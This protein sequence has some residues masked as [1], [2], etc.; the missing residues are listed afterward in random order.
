MHYKNYLLLAGLVLPSFV[1][2]AVS[3]RKKSKKKE[4]VKVEVKARES[5][6]EAD[7]KKLFKDKKTVTT[8][9]MFTI[10][11]VDESKLYFELPIT[12]LEREM[13]L[14]STVSEISNNAHGVI[15]YKP[16]EPLHVKFRKIGRGVHLCSVANLYSASDKEEDAGIDEAVRK[17]TLPSIY[18]SYKIEAYTPDSS[19]MVIDVTDLFLEDNPHLTP[20]DQF[21]IFGRKPY[22]RTTKFEKTKSLLG[23][24]KAFED[25]L[26]IK[27]YLSYSVD[28]M[29]QSGNQRAS[30]E[31]KRAFTAY[32]TRTLML[33]PDT[34]MRPRIADPRMN[35]FYSGKAKFTH[36]M[37][38]GTLPTYYARHWRV[39]PADTN[40]YKKGELVEPKQP[41]VFYVDKNF[42]DM[43][44]PYI[45]AGIQEWN[46]AFEK[47]GFKNVVKSA[48]Y[49]E[50]D[51]SFDPDNLK[52]SCVRYAPVSIMNAMGPSWDDPRTGEIINASVMVYH[53]IMKLITNWR[54]L[55]TA[56]SDPNARTMNM[57]E[58]VM[59]DALRYVIAHEIGHCLGFM[60][61]MSA[62]AVIPTDSLRSP[63]FTQKYGTTMSIMDYA[64][65]N[66]VAQPGDFEKGVKVTPPDMGVYDYYA[67]KW[68]YTPLLA[69]KTA[70]EELPILNKWIQEK[71]NDPVYR[72]GK[73]Q[74]YNT[75]D[76]S[77]QAEDL[78]DDLIKGAEYGIKNLRY[79]LSN[80]NSWVDKDDQDLM[81]RESIYR[82]MLNQYMTFILHV[83]NVKGGVYMN[84][85]MAGDARPAHAFV[86]GEYQRR[87]QQFLIN[88]LNDLD[89]IDNND[90]MKELP[91]QGNISVKIQKTLL[92]LILADRGSL[93]ILTDPAKNA[94]SLEENQDSAFKGIFAKTIK[95]QTLSTRDMTNQIDYLDYL[96]ILNRLEKPQGSSNKMGIFSEAESFSIT[97]EIKSNEYMNATNLYAEGNIDWMKK[98]E[99]EEY[100]GFAW[101][102]SLSQSKTAI[103]HIYYG[104]LIELRNLLRRMKNT[105]SKA[106]RDHYEMMLHRLEGVLN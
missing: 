76:P 80:I 33:L 34:L 69:A 18:R 51:P 15:G 25:N 4:D 11:K 102:K 28:V 90:L 77:S 74:I 79:I 92:S 78:G 96:L 2:G 22:S 14:G 43:W 89:W 72:Y 71:S 83:Y 105:G 103:D 56:A 16:K 31:S 5:K 87:A 52:Y 21:S 40:K 100:M 50:N 20:F 98:I 38:R 53:D 57:S 81:F 41:I 85:R 13:L 88:Q 30:V 73:Q 46:K 86:D 75:L 6:T 3:G 60:H 58:E 99:Q 61:N 104:K 19:A 54:F 68:L 12:M 97:P 59:G 8:K 49:P 64:R 36:N 66:H 17:S 63:S 9:G 26:I 23:D 93:A 35:I 45:H 101:F 91:L 47:I 27:S 106:N 82:A 62:S 44:K 42:P 70:E 39:E 55:Q 7:Y 37:N 67:V 65:F 84:E 94:F 24:I 48:D 10:H 1:F 95:G 29:F 32:M